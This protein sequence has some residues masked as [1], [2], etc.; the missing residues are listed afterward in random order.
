MA[1]FV[2]ATSIANRCHI[3][4]NWQYFGVGYIMING[5]DG[6]LLNTCFNINCNYCPD[7]SD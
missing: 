5:F 7:S 6:I 3:Y 2:I 4:Q 1:K